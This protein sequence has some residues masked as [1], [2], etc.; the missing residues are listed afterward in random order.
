MNLADLTTPALVV[1]LEGFEHNASTMTA[2]WPGASLR[3]HV[4]A[5][6]STA[7]AAKLAAAGH[8]GFCCATVR[9]MEGMAAAG[10]P[11]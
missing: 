6:K 9:E 3:P 8:R 11:E 5:F 7:M 10:C 4:K 1:D 2:A